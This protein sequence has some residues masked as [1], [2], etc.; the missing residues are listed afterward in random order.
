MRGRDALCCRLVRAWSLGTEESGEPT[1]RSVDFSF[2][3]TQSDFGPSQAMRPEREGG[4]GHLQDVF[5]L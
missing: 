5:T 4:L 1:G 2:I 3:L